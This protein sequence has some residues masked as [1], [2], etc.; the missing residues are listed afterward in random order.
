MISQCQTTR[1]LRTLSAVVALLLMAAPGFA[2]FDA[3]TVLGSV[4]DSSGGVV[5]GATV[6]LKNIATGIT[7]TTVSDANGDYQF[8]NVRIGTYGVR[9]ELQGF[10]IAEVEDVQVTVNARQRV[11]LTLKVGG[12]G[13]TVVVSG[14]AT[15]LETDSSDRGQVIGKEQI[16]NLP[17]NGRAY[18]DLA[19]LSPGVRRSAI[20]DSRDASFNV[21][22]LR[23]ALNSFILDG[24]DNNSYGTSNQGFSNQV[25][26]VSPDAVEEFKVQTN[27]FSAE[28][29]RTGGAVVNASMRSGTNQFR[30]TVWEFNRNDA[31]NAVGFFKPSSGVKPKLNRNQFGF[32]AGGPVIKNRTFFFADYEGFRQISKV[33]TFA[34]IPTLEQRQGILGRPIQN[35][36]T[37]E[38]YANGVIPSSAII[39][40]ARQVLAG[41]PDP[42][43]PGTANNFDSLPRREDF[44]D[45]YDVKVDHQFSSRMTAFGRFSHRKVNNFE[46]PPIPGETGS[47]AN[48]FVHVLNDQFAGGFTFTL[49][50][51]SLL[52]VRLGVSRTKAGKEPPGVGGPTM[53]ELYGIPGLPTDPRFAGGLTEQG[54]TGWTTWG[55]QNSNPQFQDPSV[56]NPRINY[57]WIRGRQSFKTGYEY[58]AINTQIDDFNP[59]YG[60]D[61]YG[62]QFSRPSTAA[63]DPAT[64]NLADFMFGAR[65][66][67]ALINPFIANLR[68]RMHFAYIQDDFK[69]RENLTLNLGLRYELATPQWE[70]DNFLTNFDP[71]TN[72]L[73]QATDGSTYDRA[74]VNPD[75]N[76]FAPR[77][78]AAYSI[79]SKTIVRGGYGVSYIHFNRLGG[80]NLLSFNGPHVVGLSI[81]QQPSQGLCGANTAPTTCFR[82]TQQGYPEGLNVP[83]NFSTLNARVNY[84]PKDNSTG[85]VQSWH[86]SLQREVL[87]NLLVDVGY[88]GNKSRDIMI[89]GD[90]NQARPNE[91]TENATLQARRP[92]QGFQEIQI[93]YGGGKGGYH[94]L[95]VKVERRYSGG[96]YLLNSF[97]WSRARDNASGHLEVQNGDNSRVNYRDVDGEFGTSG[98][99]QPLNNTT[100]FVYELPFGTGR[101]YATDLHP[102]M[103]GILGGWRVVGINTMTSGVPVNLSYSPAAAFSVSGSPTYRPNLLGDPLTPSDQRT[104]FNY[105]NP[106][107]VEIPTDRSQPFGNAPR[108]AARAPSF[109]Q[110]DL[111]L[112]KSFA[113]GSQDRRLE[114]RIEAFN[115]FNKTNFGSPD[116]NRSSS[117]FG[118]ISTTY[119]ARQIQLG[120]KLY[121]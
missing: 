101:R 14:A 54:V 108:N 42:T 9:A 110:F 86:V 36:F 97:T 82:P 6:T 71:Q 121:F 33:M 40:F 45:K 25:V 47:P 80:E 22:G 44:N 13:E 19:L 21:N 38:V 59:K 31:L 20:A 85:N 43:R 11:D 68:Q 115:L 98:Y 84:I 91:P 67:Y 96:L 99:D 61:S 116:G 34:S 81:S 15:L 28:F 26:Q 114:A 23:S 48:A 29:G 105:L 4:H 120:V 73:V 58:Q 41:L 83:A 89:L 74:L 100:S 18:A 119:P 111:G 109:Y 93:A 57:S 7:A 92:I 106:A 117:T 27:N 2:Q 94:A 3:A 102:V 63:A 78:G 53:L 65:S 24:V 10:S 46:P 72:T 39:P 104:I 64:Y 55:R 49:T 37:G 12:V 16:V 8:L 69:A 70:A 50:P 90:Y 88:I 30:G 77:I 103:E 66:A 60:R 75:R 52:E 35:P 87:R 1:A 112:H 95:Q 62:G 51:T 107:T 5:P 118:R 32:V 79:T 56:V 113:L 17:L 76:N